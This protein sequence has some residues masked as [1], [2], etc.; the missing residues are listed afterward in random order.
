[1]QNA[2]TIPDRA[3]TPA[4]PPQITPTAKVPRVAVLW[5]TSSLGLY[6]NAPFDELY[7]GVGHNNGNLAFVHAI[8]SHI[9]N[10]VSFLAWGASVEALRKAAD[11][12]VIP[13]AN[14]LGKHT[15]LGAMGE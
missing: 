5:Q 9:A 14:Q 12:I 10:P 13:C 8:V 15:E 11:V 3:E 6:S 4:A 1:M 7:K 2:T